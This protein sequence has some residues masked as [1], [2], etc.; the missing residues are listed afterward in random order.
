MMGIADSFAQGFEIGGALRA[1]SQQRELG[2]AFQEGGWGALEQAAGGQGNVQVAEQARAAQN[3]QRATLL[4]ESQRVAGVMARAASALQGVPYEQRRAR[5]EQWAPALQRQGIPA[6][7][8]A[9]F[10]P[11]DE[12][13][14]GL[15]ML[16][17][18]FNG[19]S[20]VRAGDNGEIVAVGRDGSTRVLRAARPQWQAPAGATNAFA[21][22]PETG[23]V[24]QGG[25]LPMRPAGGAGGSA[26]PSGYRWT[27]DGNM[28]PVP[29]GPADVRNTAAGQFRAA[30]LES[31]QLSLERALVAI[32]NAKRI[33][34]RGLTR[35][36]AGQVL[37]NFGGSDAFDLN[38]AL[39]PVRAILSFETLAE[40]RRNSQTGGAL[41]SIAVR[42]LE[43]LGNVYASLD[44]AQSPEAFNASLRIVQRQLQRTLQAVRAAREEAAGLSGREAQDGSPPAPPAQPGGGQ[45]TR[46]QIEQELRALD[47]AER[48]LNGR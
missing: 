46:E 36:L 39:E 47:E 28:E 37:R 3:E 38:Q 10:D 48:Q 22:D 5:I 15:M 43:L 41:G 2:S 23:E 9:T 26:A 27:A 12:A 44:T 4:Q 32:E 6:E 42:E 45:R 17:D 30:Q 31:S 18:E 34:D 21:I 25:A 1:R 33:A 8:I 40:M 7:Q 29:G 20:D 16:P 35:G 13:I 19:W 14:Q 24:R 11:T